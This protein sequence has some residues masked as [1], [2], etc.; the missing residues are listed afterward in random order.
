[1]PRLIKMFQTYADLSSV[2]RYSYRNGI[3]WVL[4]IYITACI[5]IQIIFLKV[6]IHFNSIVAEKVNKSIALIYTNFKNVKTLISHSF[7]ITVCD[8]INNAGLKQ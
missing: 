2:N 3:N 7:F 5:L 6:V 4:L 8:Y 1:M